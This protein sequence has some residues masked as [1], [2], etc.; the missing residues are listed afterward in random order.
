MYEEVFTA[1]VASDLAVKHEESYWIN[2]AGEVVELEKD[3]VGCQSAYE[4]IHLEWL[5]FVDKVSSNTSQAKDGNIGGETF[6]CTKEEDHSNALLPK[7][8]T[9]PC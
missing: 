3:A 2:A 7:M 8:P 5:V 9:L 1:L 6:L 4:L